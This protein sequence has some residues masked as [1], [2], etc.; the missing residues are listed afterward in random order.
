M[1]KVAD[2]LLRKGNN[3]T[4]VLPSTSVIEA[5]KIMAE[6]NIGSVA[7]MD[8]EKFLGIMT[9]RD[10]SRKVILKGRSSTDT[11]VAEIMSADFTPVKNNDTIEHCMALMSAKNLR[12]LPVME[13]EKLTGIISI[14]DVVKETILTHEETISHLQSYIHS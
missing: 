12:Y 7:V 2:I 5:L 1:R 8:K 4:T 9:E 13:A 11:T 14:N 3:V 6:Q 10:Y